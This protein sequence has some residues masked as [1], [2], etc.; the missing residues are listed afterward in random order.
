MCLEGVVHTGCLEKD[1][2]RRI[3]DVASAKD[4]LEALG[5]VQGYVHVRTIRLPPAILRTVSFAITGTDEDFTFD[6]SSQHFPKVCMHRD[7][8]L[9]HI[10]PHIACN[11]NEALGD[12]PES[13]PVVLTLHG[14]V[15]KR[16]LLR[17]HVCPLRHALRIQLDVNWD[18]TTVLDGHGHIR[19]S[20]N[21]D[22]SV[23][24]GAHGELA[25]SLLHVVQ[26]LPRSP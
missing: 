13:V 12:F 25:G 23:C 11:A 16:I 19:V 14:E 8:R 24:L 9:V 2:A 10:Q 7:T 4:F 15:A 17:S 1:F 21:R 5:N 22:K 26:V 20:V 3:L 18:V 6:V